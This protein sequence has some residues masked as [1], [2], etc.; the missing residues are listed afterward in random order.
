[1]F[2]KEYTFYGTHAEMV[3]ELTAKWTD[4]AAKIFQRNVDV[5]L[6]APIVGFLFGRVASVDEAKNKTTK[7]FTDQM[8]REDRGLRL[9]YQLITLLDKKSN[10]SKDSRIDSAFRKMGKEEASTELLRF[11]EYVLGGVEVLHEKIISTS[12]RESEYLS[13]L[14]DFLEDINERYNEHLESDKTLELIDLARS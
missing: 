12:S 9:N 2:K 6:F 11:N 4:S 14:Y 13:N 5:L 3:Q 7:I 10:A 8:I 1:M